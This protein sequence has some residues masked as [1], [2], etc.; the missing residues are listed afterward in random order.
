MLNIKFKKSTQFLL[1]NLF[2]ITGIVIGLVIKINFFAL[3]LVLL[4]IIIL[5]SLFCRHYLIK[6]LLISA[7]FLVIGL[8]REQFLTTNPTQTS[9]RFYNNQK[10][11]LT[12]VVVEE[13]TLGM[14]NLK[15]VIQSQS[16]MINKTVEKT[17][18]KVLVLANHF[19][20]F[21][22]GDKLKI[23]C[24][25]QAPT[26][27]NGFAYD[28]YLAQQDIYTLCY[29]PEIELIEH[30]N[31]NIFYAKL[32]Q[33][34]KHFITI[35]NENLTEPHSSFLV[36]LIFGDKSGLNNK[37]WLDK[38]NKIGISHIIAISGTN[39]SFL[40][41]IL[42][43]ICLY[44]GISIGK[45]F[46][47]VSIMLL[48]FLLMIGF[49]ASALRAGI[50]FFL[51]LLAEKL[52]RLNH[53]ANAIVFSAS[54]MLLIKPVLI[55]DIGF[56]LSFLAV[57]GLIIFVPLFLNLSKKW[58]NCFGLK[59]LLLTTLAAQIITLPLILHYFGQLS[60]I[61]P[62]ANILILPIIPA[63]M[64]LG[65]ILIFSGL[66]WGF[67]AQIIGFLLWPLLNYFFLVVKVLNNISFG[68]ANIYISWPL[69]IVLYCLIFYWW[70]K[71]SRK[72]L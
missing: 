48:L 41:I 68:S 64:I 10:V 25:L 21:V 46:Y 47:P 35:I 49:P 69:V 38:F 62:V 45:A 65:L 71:L 33:F 20:D 58:P 52:G 27:F 37:E 42:L 28:Q 12:G 9:I 4:L 39:I 32:W 29:Y 31:L 2:L 51:L 43:T 26:A 56:Q 40:A 19:S 59:Q 61:A 18:G 63:I 34:K 11:T 15:L 23:K 67:L 14:K 36:A 8:A 60:L 70:W 6:T 5:L 17:S 13:P 72:N 30:T 57:I 1:F 54:L 66:V 55:L 44:F 16:L 7:I 50:M 22:Y 3:Y 53:S 24:K